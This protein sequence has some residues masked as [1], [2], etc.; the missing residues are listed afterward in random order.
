ML[1]AYPRSLLGEVRRINVPETVQKVA[2]WCLKRRNRWHEAAKQAPFAPRVKVGSIRSPNRC[3]LGAVCD[4]SI[5][6][7]EV[8]AA[9]LLHRGSTLACQER[10][11]GS[12]LR[13]YTRH[14]D[15]RVFAVDL[16]GV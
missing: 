9:T 6:F 3:E 16:V 4:V 5:E 15:V 13:P 10:A 2:R 12:D 1:P 11:V 8:T 7:N 14:E